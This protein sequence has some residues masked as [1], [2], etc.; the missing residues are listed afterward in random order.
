VRSPVAR[1]SSLKGKEVAE[2]GSVRFSKQTVEKVAKKK[3][4]DET[5]LSMSASWQKNIFWL[6]KKLINWQ[7]G[8][9]R[10]NKYVAKQGV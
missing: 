2:D 6:R 10:T 8:I 1:A 4:E 7:T 9:K 5:S 3:R